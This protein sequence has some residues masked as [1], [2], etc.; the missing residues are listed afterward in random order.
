M[1]DRKRAFALILTASAV[2]VICASSLFL[3][4]HTHRDCTEQDCPVCAL[5]LAYSENLKTL[6][7]AV[8]T[9]IAAAAQLSLSDGVGS[10]RTSGRPSPSLVSWKVKLSN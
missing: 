9:G 7:L 4:A 2:L 1:F 3:I 5:L 6:A 10:R 8:T